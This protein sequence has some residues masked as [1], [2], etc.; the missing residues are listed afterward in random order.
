MIAVM[1]SALDCS[2][3]YLERE[4]Y[5]IFSDGPDVEKGLSRKLNPLE[6]R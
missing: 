3:V 5:V 4:C 6:N 2:G 1:L